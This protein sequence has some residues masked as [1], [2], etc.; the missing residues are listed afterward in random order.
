MY[1]A[2]ERQNAVERLTNR[3]LD[4]DVAYLDLDDAYLADLA[5]VRE[6]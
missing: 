3:L 2:A 5:A 4:S 6:Q 1:W